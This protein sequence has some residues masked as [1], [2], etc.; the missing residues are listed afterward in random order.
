MDG[1]GDRR[2][3]LADR[4]RSASLQFQAPYF[5]E[6]LFNGILRGFGG[7]GYEDCDRR[8]GNYWRN[9]RL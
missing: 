3:T 7:Q 9:D 1:W 5:G 8:G 2:E 4:V 6:V